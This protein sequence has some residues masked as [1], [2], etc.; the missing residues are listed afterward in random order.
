VLLAES[1]EQAAIIGSA[2]QVE[3]ILA[4]VQGRAGRFAEAG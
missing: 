2:N 3:A 1:K 4:G